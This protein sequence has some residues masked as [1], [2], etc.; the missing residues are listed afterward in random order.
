MPSGESLPDAAWIA[1]VEKLLKRGRLVPLHPEVDFEIAQLLQIESSNVPDQID[2]RFRQLA[3]AGRTEPGWISGFDS[4]EERA[5]VSLLDDHGLQHLKGWLH[6]QLPLGGLT[7]E[8][9]DVASNQRVDFVIAHPSGV[10]LCIE[11][12]GDQHELQPVADENRDHSL[13]LA[14]FT[15]IRIPASEVRAGQGVALNNL[16][17]RLRAI[18][19]VGFQPTA[20]DLYL[21]AAKKIHQIQLALWQAVS[22]GLVECGAEVAVRVDSSSDPFL[23]GAKLQQEIIQS[24]LSDL[25]SLI[26]D[27]A[28]LYGESGRRVRFVPVEPGKK[29]DVILAFSPCIPSDEIPVL[30]VRD[31]YLPVTIANDVAST[32]TVITADPTKE[33]CENLLYR[34]F[35]WNSFREGQYEA[36][37]RCLRGKDAI[38]L[39]PTGAGK[40]VAFQLAS[41]VRPGSCLVIDPIISLIED[42]RENLRLV[43]IDRSTQITGGIDA[44]T[45]KELLALFAR[46]EYLFCYIAPERLQDQ[47]FRE[48][49]RV[50]TTHA[51]VSLV[52]IDEAHCVSEWGHDFRPAYLNVADTSREY[53]A[54]NGRVPPIMGLTGTASRAVLKDVQRELHIE[55]FDAIITPNSFDRAELHFSGI[56]CRS[57][58]KVARLRGY[59]EALP[60]RFSHTSSTFFDTLG[61]DTMS[62]LVFCPWVNG[63][64]G[65]VRVSEELA[66]QLSRKVPCYSGKTPKGVEEQKWQKQKRDAATRF[67]QNEFPVM[68]CTKAFGMGIDKP[69]IR[70]TVHYGLPGSIES[71]Y[72]E[73]G[74]AGRDRRKAYCTILFSDDHRHRNARILNPN[75][76]IDEVHRELDSIRRADEDDVTRALFFHKNAFRGVQEDMRNV[77]SLI[78]EL[79][80]VSESGVKEIKFDDESRLPKEKAIHRLLTIGVVSDYTV[81]FSAG[82]FGVRM[83]GIGKEEI[84]DHLYRYVAAYQRGQAKIVAHRMSRFH[85]DPHDDFVR[86]CMK[87]LIRFVYEVI[88][89]SRR[90]ALSEMLAVCEH[91]H[92]DLAMRKRILEYLGTSAFT[93]AIDEVLDAD[94][95]GLEVVLDLAESVRSA[96]DAGQLRGESGRALESYPDHTGL[97]LLRAVSEGMT[98]NPDIPTIVENIEASV[99]FAREKYE[100]QESLVITTVLAAARLVGDARPELGHAIVTGLIRSASNSREAAREVVQE[101]SIR[102]SEPAVSFLLRQLTDQVRTLTE[103]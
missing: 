64:Y 34:I 55:D 47:S 53:C 19:E 46:G 61:Q 17:Q 31:I 10:H 92:D 102:L 49:L 59:L 65:V 44:E 83:S 95:G 63:E 4:D 96:L 15:V 101:I 25:N 66:R 45:R 12:D 24:G 94:N 93:E 21:G 100:L 20:S 79:E 32:S 80:G 28:S 67:K 41:L 70:Y 69:N 42:Q 68:A 57:T 84:V 35:G 86:S 2:H 11:I 60:R 7:G 58:E 85:D 72:Q 29:A 51:S 36:I 99:R 82:T 73:A 78:K 52:A 26:S 88:E 62:G 56:P 103:V 38:V 81:Q 30:I 97:R 8:A 6:R 91:A 50:L 3:H 87:E 5:F 77:D 23:W 1:I 74:R 33:T 18:P 98:T 90:Q 48:S 16:Y 39:L 71:F 14:G 89:R 9:E 76:S 75:M 40:S 27:V 37:E 22:V 43:G 54:T 13:E